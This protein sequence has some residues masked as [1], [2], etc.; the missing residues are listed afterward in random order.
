MFVCMVVVVVVGWYRSLKYFN[1]V[2]NIKA[3]H[4][5][6]VSLKS[7]NHMIF[8]KVFKNGDSFFCCCSLYYCKFS[9]YLQMYSRLFFFLWKPKIYSIFRY[10]HAFI[11]KI[12][13][14]RRNVPTFYKLKSYVYLDK[15]YVISKM[16]ESKE[17]SSLKLFLYTSKNWWNSFTTC[18]QCVFKI[19]SKIR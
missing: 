13:S 18:L 17:L 11:V 8:V 16:K 15:L 2:F 14:W 12:D 3:I 6:I 5:W 9:W 19:L 10:A 4:K 7:D 1:K